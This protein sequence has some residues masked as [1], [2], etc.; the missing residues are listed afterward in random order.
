MIR[1]W[2]KRWGV[3]MGSR[4]I[5]TEGVATSVAPTKYRSSLSG[6][7]RIAAEAAPTFSRAAQAA[8]K[9]SVARTSASVFSASNAEWPEAGE[10]A[11]SAFGQAL[12]RSQAFCT[13]QTTS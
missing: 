9:A 7:P 4:G 3:A 13:G 1:P 12:C 8:A 10:I 11:S 5:Q 2:Q 6:T